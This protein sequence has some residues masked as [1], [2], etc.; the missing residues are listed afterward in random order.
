MAA[1]AHSETDTLSSLTR[2]P[3]SEVKK[4]GW[5]GLMR[6]LQAEGRVLVTNHSEP[7][8]VILS[9]R[10]YTAFVRLA[11]QQEGAAEAALQSLRQGFD[12]RLA[13]L[14]APDAGDRLR[15]VMGRPAKLGGKV[16][17][18]ATY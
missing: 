3:A 9:V 18:G 17:V 16:K 12:E 13:V 6:T 2:T 10:D 14:Q 7:E 5:R 11:Q 15:A 1:T 4:H 8:A